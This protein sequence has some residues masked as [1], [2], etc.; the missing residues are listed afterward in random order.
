MRLPDFYI[1][2][3]YVSGGTL[4]SFGR[5]ELDNSSQIS[6]ITFQADY[7]ATYKGNIYGLLKGD[8]ISGTGYSTAG[9]VCEFVANAVLP[10]EELNV[11]DGI[12][13]NVSEPENPLDKEAWDSASAAYETAKQNLETAAAALEQAE[14]DLET[15]RNSGSVG[16]DG[17]HR[18]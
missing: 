5:F 13:R 18:W 2:V 14:E 11:T 6:D 4:N 9:T 10:G 8:S 1:W 7:V 3:K 15:I 16:V 12:V 17:R